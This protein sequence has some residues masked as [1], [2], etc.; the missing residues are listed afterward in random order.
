MEVAEGEVTKLADLELRYLELRYK[1]LTA[2]TASYYNEA[3]PADLKPDQKTAYLELKDL[4]PK[5]R[6]AREAK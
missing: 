1:E 2:I 3:N 5:I 6:K 4:I